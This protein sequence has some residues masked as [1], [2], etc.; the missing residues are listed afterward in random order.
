MGGRAAVLNGWVEGD[1]NTR[2]AI[3]RET[4][5]VMKKHWSDPDVFEAGKMLLRHPTMQTFMKEAAE[6][7]AYWKKALVF[8][9]NPSAFVT[10][11]FLRSRPRF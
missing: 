7:D 4:L 5:A 11:K 1:K 10:R 8:I 6:T 9:D 2:L 3:C